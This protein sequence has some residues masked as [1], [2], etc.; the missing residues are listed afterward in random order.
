VNDQWVYGVAD[1][2]VGDTRMPPPPRGHRP[3]LV[4]VYETRAQPEQSTGRSTVVVDIQCVFSPQVWADLICRCATHALLVPVVGS[5]WTYMDGEL[6]GC[7]TGKAC[8]VHAGVVVV[9]VVWVTVGV[10]DC[11]AAALS[12]DRLLLLVSIR[13]RSVL[14]VDILVLWLFDETEDCGWHGLGRYATRIY[15]FFILKKD[16]RYV[17]LRFRFSDSFSASRTV[18]VT[19]ECWIPG[20]PGKVRRI[21]LFI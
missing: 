19:P 8:G 16:V 12:S 13:R 5:D 6:R 15:H 21:V 7:G 11:A 17:V 9:V 1:H 20:R 3:P 14:K 18:R 10:A 4:G 2:V